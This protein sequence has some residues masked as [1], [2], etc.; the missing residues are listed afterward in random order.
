MDAL[1]IKEII[2]TPKIVKFKLMLGFY[3]KFLL[4]TFTKKLKVANGDWG[5]Y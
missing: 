2:A 1:E 5:D 4:F 3:F